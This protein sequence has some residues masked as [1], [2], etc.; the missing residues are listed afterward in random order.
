LAKSIID[1]LKIEYH[2]EE[3]HSLTLAIHVEHKFIE[4]VLEV[5]QI[6]LTDLELSKFKLQTHVRAEANGT[7]NSL[8]KS[9]GDV[10]KVVSEGWGANLDVKT[11]DDKFIRD[12]ID[13]ALK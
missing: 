1:G 2:V 6:N 3:G 11:N 4:F 8:D 13:V 5:I 7:L 12:L 9:N 10:A